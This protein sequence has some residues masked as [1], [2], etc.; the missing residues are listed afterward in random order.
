MQDLGTI[1]GL[2]EVL[3]RNSLHQDP[4]ANMVFQKEHKMLVEELNAKIKSAEAE[5]EQLKE[6]VL[7]Q[8]Y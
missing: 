1:K 5:R 6:T 3:D 7:G 2:G 4:F 8:T